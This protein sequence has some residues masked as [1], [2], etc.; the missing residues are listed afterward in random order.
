MLPPN[1]A[2][3]IR[4]YST[5]CRSPKIS[6]T[7]RATR[8][9]SL[10][11]RDWMIMEIMCVKRV[12]FVWRYCRQP[13]RYYYASIG[14]QHLEPVKFWRCIDPKMCPLLNRLLKFAFRY[15]WQYLIW[16]SD[17]CCTFFSLVLFFSWSC[18]VHTFDCP[19]LLGTVLTLLSGRLWDTWSLFCG[20]GHQ[21]SQSKPIYRATNSP[22]TA[23]WPDR[24]IK[25]IIPKKAETTIRKRRRRRRRQIKEGNKTK[26]KHCFICCP[27]NSGAFQYFTLP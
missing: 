18:S 9:E 22:Q 10:S 6:D 7:L 5:H 12:C 4:V 8:P 1:S 25:I 2:T 24:T 11:C 3:L 13:I 17:C 27:L 21:T 14:L 26:K 16:F 20:H 19:Y 23:H 15:R